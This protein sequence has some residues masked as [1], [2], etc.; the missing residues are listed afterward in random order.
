MKLFTRSRLIDFVVLAF[1]AIYLAL[2]SVPIS[3]W[4]YVGDL[5]L[6]ETVQGGP[7]LIEYHGGAVRDFMGSYTVIARDFA[8]REIFCDASSGP[9]KYEVGAPRPDPL[10]MAWWAPG[11]PRCQALSAGTYALETCWKVH[12][13][14]GGLVPSKVGCT[15][16]NLTIRPP[17]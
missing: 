6:P 5:A 10:T 17:D 15:S 3:R 9:F 14:F 12:A 16:A 1:G 7:I 13:P 11:D 2:A 4:Y 8:T